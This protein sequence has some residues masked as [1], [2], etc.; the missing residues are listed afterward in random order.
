LHPSN[1]KVS[2]FQ[3]YAHGVQPFCNLIKEASTPNAFTTMTK[4]DQNK[5]CSLHYAADMCRALIDG[6]AGQVQVQRYRGIVTAA[7]LRENNVSVE[8]PGTRVCRTALLTLIWYSQ[9]DGPY[10]SEAKILLRASKS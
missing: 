1:T 5:T 6:L 4:L 9:Q 8:L 2:F 3:A 7:D 10:A